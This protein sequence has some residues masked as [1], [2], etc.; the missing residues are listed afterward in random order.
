MASA[1]GAIISPFQGDPPFDMVIEYG[2]D[3]FGWEKEGTLIR[4][5]VGR[6][7]WVLMRPAG[8][9]QCRENVGMY[10]KWRKSDVVVT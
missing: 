3:E 9:D 8:E 6:G 10:K 7:W 2:N 4:V 5:C 1:D